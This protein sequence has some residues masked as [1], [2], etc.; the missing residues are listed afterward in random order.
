MKRKAFVAVVGVFLLGL[1]GGV[2]V[3]KVYPVKHLWGWAWHDARGGGEHRGGGM[4]RSGKRDSSG[5]YIRML[6]RELDLS[7]RQ[8]A[9]IGPLLS[10][11]RRD[12]YQARIRSLEEADRIILDFHGKIR[13]ALD[14]AQA[15][16]LERRTDNFREWRRKKRERVISRLESL[17]DGN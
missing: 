6:Q 14:E 16:K 7:D 2:L 4:R 12:L 17:R 13:P 3:G 9:E 8:M 15:R 5:R 11:T 10:Q 1:V